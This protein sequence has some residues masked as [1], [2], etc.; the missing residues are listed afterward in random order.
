M[1]Y[2]VFRP[3]PYNPP[4]RSAIEAYLNTAQLTKDRVTFAEVVQALT[5]GTAGLTPG[6]VEQIALELG[7]K[8]EIR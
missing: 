7:Y 4:Q 8:V 3:T 6:M 5:P 1:L 2:V